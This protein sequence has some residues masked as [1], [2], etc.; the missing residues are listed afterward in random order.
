MDLSPPDRLLD[1]R[2]LQ[3]RESGVESKPDNR[4]GESMKPITIEFTVKYGDGSFKEDSG[5]FASL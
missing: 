1:S 4:W 2:Q 5:T 3:F